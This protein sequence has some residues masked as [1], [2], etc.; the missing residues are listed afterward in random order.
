MAGF[1]GCLGYSI[2]K[3][4]AASVWRWASIYFAIAEAFGIRIYSPFIHQTAIHSALASL[5]NH[6]MND[7]HDHEIDYLRN[8][9]IGLAISVH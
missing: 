4:G 2:Q 7:T 3:R 9:F 1:A 8:N 5:K 6:N